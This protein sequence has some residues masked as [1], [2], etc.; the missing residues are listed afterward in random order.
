MCVCNYAH[1]GFTLFARVSAYGR[2]SSRQRLTL[3]T[4]FNPETDGK[5]EPGHSP[6]V[7]ALAKACDERVK[8]WPHMLPYALW[9]DCTTHKSMTGLCQLNS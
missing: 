3:T 5:I 2:K 4:T 8:D 1:P 7:K 6:I 9:A